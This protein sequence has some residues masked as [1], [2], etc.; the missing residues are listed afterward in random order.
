MM[1]A[2]IVVGVWLCSLAHARLLHW[3]TGSWSDD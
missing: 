2:G 1:I 3:D